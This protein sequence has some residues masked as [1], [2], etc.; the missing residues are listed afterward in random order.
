MVSSRIDWK[1][2]LG[3]AIEA[4]GMDYS[5]LCE[6][7][8]RLIGQGQEAELLNRL[9]QQCQERGWLK[10]RGQI[11]T[12]ATHV[13]AAVRH[14]NRLEVVG[15]T[16]RQALE[17]LA[18]LV[19]EWLQSWVERD[20]YD[21]YGRRIES[22]RLAKDKAEQQA[23]ALRVGLDGHEL[24]ER[25]RAETSP[26]GLADIGALETLRQVWVQQ[27]LVQDEQ[28]YWRGD[29]QGL[30]PASLLIQSPYD[31]EA[32][33]RTKRDLNWTGYSVHLS[34]TYDQ[35]GL[36]NL[37]VHVETTPATQSDSSVVPQIHQN[38][39]NQHLTPKQHLFDTAYMSVVN[40]Q[41]SQTNYGIDLVAPMPQDTS[42]QAQLPEG[43]DLTR[44]KMDWQDETVQCPAG[45]K[46]RSW[47]PRTESDGVE[48]IEVQFAKADCQACSLRSLCT[49]SQQR[50]RVIKFK[51][52]AQFEHLQAARRR[53][54]TPTF[55]ATY[56][57]RAGVEGTLSQ[58]IN[59]F[60]MRRSRY[61]GLAKTHL[62]QVLSA[63]ALNLFRLM[64]WAQ[65]K[66][67][68]KSRVSRLA[69]LAPAA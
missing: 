38:L 63:T 21:R 42:W 39:E 6:F 46:S 41:Q 8:G 22:Y 34:E 25:I 30:P 66:P 13:V 16:L 51:P 20:W 14:L 69:A 15:E 10:E 58:A 19:P 31:L 44:F 18:Q 17:V 11:R 9:L 60:H 52:Q 3:L 26:P 43:L 68:A 57:L 47:H 54:Q 4:T 45:C 65:H 40:L 1:Y 36:P 24:L 12:D 7:R 49:R 59:S 48:V 50:P 56:R 35:I 28:L 67:Q 33:N 64:D 37:I 62:Q 61:I 2:A 55:K 27:Y 53:Q 32:R 5:V 23:W 29:E